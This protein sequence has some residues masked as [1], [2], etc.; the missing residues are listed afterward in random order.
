MKFSNGNTEEWDFKANI[1]HSNDAMYNTLMACL[2][3]LQTGAGAIAYSMTRTNYEFAVDRFNVMLFNQKEGIYHTSE[4]TDTIYIKDNLFKL[5]TTEI[6][7]CDFCRNIIDCYYSNQEA[8]LDFCDSKNRKSPE[9]IHS[10]I[11]EIHRLLPQKSKYVSV[12]R[13]GRTNNTDIMKAWVTGEYGEKAKMIAQIH[14]DKT[15]TYIDEDAKTD[16]YVQNIL[17][18]STSWNGYPFS[19]CGYPYPYYCF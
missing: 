1:G 2:S 10:L 9:A 13:P 14:N 19:D 6:S 8:W 5:E 18:H 4:K 3:Y 17:A 11:K 16:P 15:V 12:V 7:V